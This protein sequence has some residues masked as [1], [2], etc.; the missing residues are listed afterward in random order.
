VARAIRRVVAGT[1]L[2]TLLPLGD[3]G[4]LGIGQ[5]VVESHFG[6]PFSGWVPVRLGPDEAIDPSCISVSA[7]G[8][9]PGLARPRVEVTAVGGQSR[10]HVRTRRPVHEPVLEVALRVECP[11]LPQAVRHFT[12][13]LD[14]PGLV[15]GPTAKERARG[16]S[17]PAAP[18]VPTVAAPQALRTDPAP[19]ESRR[20]RATAAPAA[21]PDGAHTVVV[22]P[23]DTL[24]RIAHRTRPTS[25]AAEH[26]RLLEAFVVANPGVFP[27]GNP[28]RLPVSARLVV[29]DPWGL[30]AEG[31]STGAPD[32]RRSPVGPVP[33]EGE[34]PT[35]AR[36]ASTVATEPVTVPT[37][38][39]PAVP[40]ATPANP[41][42]DADR[43]IRRAQSVTQLTR[44]ARLLD[45]MD[46][47]LADAW[48]RTQRLTETIARL[49]QELRAATSPVVQGARAASA[50][51]SARPRPAAPAD[52]P[53]PVLAALAPP[54]HGAPE[55]APAATPLPAATPV[56]R[57]PLAPAP[58]V[59]MAG[60]AGTDPFGPEAT[61]L[62]ASWP[63]QRW[64]PVGAALLLTGAAA[65]F[66]PRRWRRAR[67]TGRGLADDS[68]SGSALA[69]PGPA[70]APPVPAARRGEQSIARARPPAPAPALAP[71]QTAPAPAPERV[72]E[73]HEPTLSSVSELAALGQPPADES[74]PTDGRPDPQ[75]RTAPREAPQAAVNR[76]LLEA[77]LHLLFEQHDEARGTLEQAVDLD[78]A[79]RPDLR[80]WK[81][82]FDLLRQTDDRP[83]FDQYVTR[84]QGRYN[85]TPPSWGGGTPEA[86][87]GGLA[88]R[89]P[90]VMSKIVQLWGTAEGVELLNSLLLDDRGGN[91]R[92]FDYEIG[93]EISF[94]RD[95]LDRRGLGVGPSLTALFD[96]Q[97]WASDTARL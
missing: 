25:T 36:G 45:E 93:E 79:G 43:P 34:G 28:S 83:R 64:Y 56:A 96:E 41:A 44:E 97:R 29:P 30:A 8:E 20:V 73:A 10:I 12:A 58:S 3:A 51:A 9:T 91:R 90:R 13:L 24:S 68:G 18:A 80:P 60:P 57:E 88:E 50:L 89:F 42:T 75:A 65:A 22:R 86:P 26:K 95:V 2:I 85:I 82:L 5:L 39:A 59:A 21:P 46:Q 87:E 11:G 4:A 52:P 70:S 67:S 38:P 94:L 48:A 55:L 78:P 15:W 49:S 23:G 76:L 71:P 35:R 77:E 37:T 53:A 40:A 1:A 47:D 33:T 72:P 7:G 54:P 19:R 63:W 6:Q 32:A 61:L 27:D 17:A 81:M 69:A 66:L 74:E 31:G 14:P 92:G 84:F 16:M 62:E